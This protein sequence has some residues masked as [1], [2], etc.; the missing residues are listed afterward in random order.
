MNIVY[1]LTRKV[2]R[3]ILPSV[4]SLMEHN[5]KAK[6]Y[7]LCEDDTFPFELPCEATI[8]NVKDQKYFTPSGVNYNNQFTYINLLKVCYPYI[9]QCNKVIHLDIDT[10]INDTLEPLWKTDL[11]N[12]WF[13]AVPEYKGKYKPFGDLYY[14]MGV[15]VINL[16][17][18]RKDKIMDTMANYLN[19][20]PQPWADQDAWNKY[21]LEQDKAVTVPTR[22]NENVMT[23]YSTDPAIVHYCSIGDW[24]E[25]TGIYRREYLNKW[26]W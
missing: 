15:A 20:I 8:I 4:C 11:K 10:I 5:P 26:M 13:G 18:M 12:K 17:Q 9:L 22:Y 16:Q 1:A 3:K 25:N 6:V 19:T 23:G 7:I 21:G 24:F 14:N 2:Y